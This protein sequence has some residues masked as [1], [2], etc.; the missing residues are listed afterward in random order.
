MRESSS[1]GNSSSTSRARSPSMPWR[2]K[3]CSRRRAAASAELLGEAAG[4]KEPAPLVMLFVDCGESGGAVVDG[5]DAL[6]HQRPDLRLE[7]GRSLRMLFEVCLGVLAALADALISVR[8]PRPGLADDVLLEPDVDERTRAADPLAVGD[9]ELRHLERRRD[10]VLDDLHARARTDDI[11][12]DL[13]ALQLADVQP[14]GGI[15]LQSQTAGGRLRIAEHHADLLAE[16]VDEHH[17]GARLGDRGGEFAQ[18]FRHQARLQA[19]VRIAHVAF[20][21]SF[22]HERSDRIH[23][24]DVHGVGAH[25]H[26]RDVERLVARCRLR[27]EQVV[28]VDADV[29][30]VGGIQCVLDVDERRHAAGLLRLRDAVQR[31][32]GLARGFGPVDLDHPAARQAADAERQVQRD[33]SGG[34]HLDLHVGG[35]LAQFHDGALAE[36]ALDLRERIFQGFVFFGHRFLLI[37]NNAFTYAAGSNACNW[38]TFSPKPT[39]WTGRSTWSMIATIIPPFAV[40]S[41]FVSTMPVTSAASWN[42]LAWESAFCPVVA[43][44]TSRVSCGAPSTSRA[45]MRLIFFNSSIRLCLV[46]SLP[47]VSM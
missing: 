20:D 15:E 9:V 47:A 46:C 29:A 1:S 27:H 6:G 21:L 25:Q 33:R 37:Q 39:Y 2:S 10:F 3:S 16:L 4:S 42:S 40:P 28:E 26:L 18:R 38:S 30:R 8:V 19:H 23:H 43:S 34:K 13:D 32:R 24:D 41:S 5:G 11:R 36:L 14:H 12:A 7:L 22:G 44:S 31:Q 45:T 17:R 35:G